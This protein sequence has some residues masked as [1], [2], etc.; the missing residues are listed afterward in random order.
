MNKPAPKQLT[1]VSN[2]TVS[3]NMQRV[4]FHG[5]DIASFPADCAGGY[6]KLLF[7]SQGNTDLSGLPEGQRPHMRSYTIKSFS[8]QN[9]TIVVDFVRHET[10]DLTMGFASRWVMSAKAGDNIF[11]VGPGQIKPIE[12][13]VDWYFMVADMTALPALSAKIKELP[14]DAKGYAV[15]KV[16]SFDDIQ[17]IDIP[18]NMQIRWITKESCLLTT[19]KELPWLEGEV[20]VW[21]AT[22]FEE[23][24][25]LRQYF[26][27]EHAV[28]R[29]RIYISSYWKRGVSEDGH[30][31]AKRL[32]KENQN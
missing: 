19:V 1:V 21:S 3:P 31:A 4:T 12:T 20:F 25:E 5:D 14:S 16:V 15:I 22:E 27:D 32:D 17:A 28:D 11:I 6:I 30:K 26:R 9:S 29:D 2:D 23:M 24:R 7:D 10:T 8:A 13:S 18:S